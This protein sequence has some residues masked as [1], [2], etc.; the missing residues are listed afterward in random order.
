MWKSGR[1]RCPTYEK[2]I[3]C[4]TVARAPSPGKG[5]LQRPDRDFLKDLPRVR[6]LIKSLTS[7]ARENRISIQEE[8]DTKRN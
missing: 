5:I 7:T 8:L 1:A 4:I 3:T 2:P 6:K